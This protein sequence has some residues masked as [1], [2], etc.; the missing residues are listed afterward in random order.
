M[1]PWSARGDLLRLAQPLDR[2]RF[3]HD[4]LDDLG[5]AEAAGASLVGDL[6]LD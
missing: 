4:S 2:H 1:G 6:V 3:D 5:L